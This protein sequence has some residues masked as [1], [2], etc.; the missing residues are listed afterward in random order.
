MPQLDRLHEIYTGMCRVL[1]YPDAYG[2]GENVPQPLAD[3][4][5]SWLGILDKMM[6]EQG[7]V[8][9]STNTGLEAEL[10]QDADNPCHAGSR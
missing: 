9:E 3:R 2:L 10:S 5:E 7:K 8:V 6:L 4:L 1:R